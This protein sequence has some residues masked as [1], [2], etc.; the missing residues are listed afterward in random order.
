MSENNVD[1]SLIQQ[2]NLHGRNVKIQL[3]IWETVHLCYSTSIQMNQY[4]FIILLIWHLDQIVILHH[5]FVESSQ[6]IVA[7]SLDFLELCV[8][9]CYKE[10]PSSMDNGYS[11]L[12]SSVLM[13]KESYMDVWIKIATG[14]RVDLN[15]YVGSSRYNQ[16]LWG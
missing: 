13:D 2:G 7:D 12:K 1:L 16:C 15:N 3:I 14:K 9:K 8:S 10:T 11:E 6:S 5:Y 4:L